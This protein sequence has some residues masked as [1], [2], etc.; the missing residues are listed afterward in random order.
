MVSGLVSIV[1]ISYR[2]IWWRWDNTKYIDMDETA[3]G[4]T[5]G[6]FKFMYSEIISVFCLFGPI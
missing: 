4:A 3:H 1:R 6:I 2:I 5:T